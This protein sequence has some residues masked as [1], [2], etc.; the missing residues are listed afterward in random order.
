MNLINPEAAGISSAAFVQ[1]LDEF[2]RQQLPLHSLLISRGNILIFE[3]YYAPY[4]KEDLHRMFSVGKSLTALAIGHLCDQ[5]QL[6]LDDPII[7]YFPEYVPT[8]V[9]KELAALTIRHMLSMQ[10]CH[11]FTTYKKDLSSDWVRSFFQTP[12]SHMPGT[13]FCYDTSSTHTLS[14]LIEKISGLS[15]MEYMQ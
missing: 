12:P 11:S 14:A 6:S 3:G 2:E 5:G 7:N 15:L 4:G 13:V 10:T 1:L 9:P 8:P